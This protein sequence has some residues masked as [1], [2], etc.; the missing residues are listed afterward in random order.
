MY[1]YIRGKILLILLYFESSAKSIIMIRINSMVMW[2][3]SGLNP[4]SLSFVVKYFLRSV[5]TFIKLWNSNQALCRSC[6]LF[7][8]L[9]VLRKLRPGLGPSSGLW[10]PTLCSVSLLGSRSRSRRTLRQWVF[11]PAGPLLRTPE[12][13]TTWTL[14]LKVGYNKSN[15]WLKTAVAIEHEKYAYL[16]KTEHFLQK[17]IYKYFLKEIKWKETEKEKRKIENGQCTV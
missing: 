13:A 7:S 3:H 11:S 16:K 8:I 6:S 15:D 12:S 5:Q 17:L 2:P 9:S 1:I 10:R 14:G 4:E